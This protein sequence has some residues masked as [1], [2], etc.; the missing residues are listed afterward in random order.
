MASR[1]LAVGM[2]FLLQTLIGILG[3]VSLLSHYISLHHTDHRL[4]PTDL[5]LMHLTISNSL[6]IV[7][8]GVPQTMEAF[9]LK[10][11]FSNS[12]CE[13]LFYFY[14]VSRGV[15]MSTTCILSVF[16]TVRVSP[17]DSC[18]K[19]LRVKAPKYVGFS[20][21]ICWILYM[22][23]NLIFPVYNLHEST[24]CSSKDIMRKRDLGYCSVK[25]FGNLSGILYAALVIFPEVVLSMLTIWASCSMVFTL[26]RHKQQVQHIHVAPKS[27]AES[28][29]TQSILLLVSTFMCFYTLSSALHACWAILHNPIRWLVN[30]TTLITLCFPTVS[31]FL[32]MRRGSTI[33]TFFFGWTWNRKPTY[34]YRNKYVANCIYQ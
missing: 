10:E 14:R 12:G 4:K 19:N 21:S 3:N 7:F 18:W 11:F 25:E 29:A 13:L 27:S 32:L 26:L 15:S 17:I 20:I 30:T 9:G 22:F 6:Y 16:Q 33:A 28:R 23:V 34:H 5:L 24:K 2:I 8:L 31:P 1:E